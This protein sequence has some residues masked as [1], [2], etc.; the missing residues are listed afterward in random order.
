MTEQDPQKVIRTILKHDRKLTS[1]KIALLRA[2]NDVVLSFPDMRNF[3]KNVAVPVRVL[4]EYWIMYYWAFA[5]RDRPILQGPRSLR[6]GRLR[7]DMAFRT[8]LASVRLEW[9][10]VIGRSSRPSDGF[11]LVSE[12][13]VPRKRSTYPESLLR[14][15]HDAVENICHTIRYPIQYAG[16]GMWSV[17]N[18]PIR[19]APSRVDLACIPGTKPEDFCLIVNA[20]LW[21]TFRVMS[22]WIESLCIHEWCLFTEQVSQPDDTHYDRGDVYRLL[23][24]RPDNRRP[25][26]WERN[27]IELLISEGTVFICPW[28]LIQIG[29]GVQYDIDHLVP[30]SVYPTNELWNL[31]PS[32]PRFNSHVKRDRLPSSERLLTAEPVIA[33][34]YENYGRSTALSRAIKEDVSVRF[35]DV[36]LDSGRFEHSVASRVIDFIEQIAEARNIARFG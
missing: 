20:D 3:H 14:A 28:T 36:D 24:D 22:V 26:T 9:E 31:A 19:D 11:F 7:D 27:N 23:T 8:Q 12:I 33:Q 15:F 17:F 18:R 2:I 6:D 21:E 34:V 35:A 4:A 5:G 1:Y 25:L 13:R 30:V 16:P 32:D 10:A 29:R